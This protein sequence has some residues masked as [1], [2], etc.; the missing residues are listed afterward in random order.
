VFQA[1][2]LADVPY[3]ISLA[4]ITIYMGAH[5]GLNARQRQQ[6]DLQQGALAPL[7]ASAALLGAYC[8]VKFF[9]NFSLQTFFD[10]YFW[11]VGSIAIVGAFAPPARRV[12]S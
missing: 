5:R 4:V 7:A 10:C 6:I 2:N 1:N 11:L 8:L 12:V 3:F 9:P